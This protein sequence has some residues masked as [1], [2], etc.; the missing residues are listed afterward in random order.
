MARMP[1]W[2]LPLL[3]FLVVAAAVLPYART[4]DYQF[5]WDDAY[6]IGP[7]L[8]VRGPADVAR[9]WNT[10]FDQFLKDE[11]MTRNYFRPAVLYTLAMDRA[12]S[13]ENPR[14]FHLTNVALYAATCFFLWLFAWGLSGRPVAAALGTILFALHPTHAES[15]A[16]VSGRTD[17]QAALFLFAALW[18]AVRFGPSIANPMWKLAPAAAL[19]LPGLFSKEVALFG[20]PLLVLALWLR[21]RKLAAG[22]LARASGAVVAA[23]AVY[24]VA[25]FSVLGSHP[26]PGLAPVEGAAAQLFTSVALVARYLPLLLVPVR[27][28][29]RHEIAPV[30]T[31]DLAFVAG[32]VA[33]VALGAGLWITL[34]RRSPWSLPL[35]LFALT[36]LPVC[37]VKLL[38]GALLAERFLFVPS[39]ALALAVTVGIAALPGAAGASAAATAA[40]AA[41]ALACAGWSYRRWRATSS[42]P[43]ADE[44]GDLVGG[45]TDRDP[46][47]TLA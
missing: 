6:L 22:D 41:A 15:V 38:S 2:L 5:V 16:F 23:V 42:E 26:I 34:R 9:L 39:A 28:S 14:G 32:A 25:R 21:D 47:G 36:L 24:L 11:A 37:Y 10:P 20:A 30:E 33:L 45:R 3:A 4:L 35:A 29:A 7:T 40:A 27:L 12:S 18:A 44:A 31:P 43:V 17:V 1:R 46:G 19:L 13:G 8:D